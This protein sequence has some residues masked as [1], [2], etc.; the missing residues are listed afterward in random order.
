VTGYEQVSLTIELQALY[1]EYCA[2]LDEGRF[3]QWPKFFTVDCTY[4]LIP[5]EN[6]DAG[7][8]LATLSFESRGMLEDRVFGITQ[9]LFH[10]PYYQ[11]HILSPVL[12]RSV[13]ENVIRCEASYLVVRTKRD[14]LSEVFNTGRYLDV[15]IRHEGALQF[16]ERV[17]VF[18]SE[19]IPNSIIYPI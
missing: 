17:C 16:R 5:R 8:A 12:I 3:E 7:R 15:V 1:G 19:L 11:R 2:C 6:H 4:K 14:E 18:D 13:D 9:T 10:A